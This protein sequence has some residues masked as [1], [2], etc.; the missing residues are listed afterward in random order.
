MI[1]VGPATV[2]TRPSPFISVMASISRDDNRIALYRYNIPL[3]SSKY[4]SKQ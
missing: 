2:H 1:D 4:N 3:Q